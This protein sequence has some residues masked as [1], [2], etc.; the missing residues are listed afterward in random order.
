MSVTL[1]SYKKPNT[2]G[3]PVQYKSRYENFI[4]GEWVPPVGG[5]YFDNPSPVDGKVFTRVPR[6]KKE[7]IDLAVGKAHQARE[8]WGNTSAAKRSKIL[9][10]IADRIDQNRE[11]LALSETWDNGKPI[12]EALAADLPLAADH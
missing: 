4:G 1:S 12:R 8:K 7:D 9:L 2:E 11:M 5:E 6:S 10:K 3:S